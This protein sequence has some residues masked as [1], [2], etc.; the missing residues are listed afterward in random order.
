MLFRSASESDED[1][2]DS[3]N[4]DTNMVQVVTNEVAQPTADEPRRNR[5]AQQDGDDRPRRRR[6]RQNDQEAPQ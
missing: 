1:F 6:P 5:D 2:D 3:E 4:V